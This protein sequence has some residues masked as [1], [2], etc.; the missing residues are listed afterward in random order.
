M[1]RLGQI[2]VVALGQVFASRAKAAGRGKRPLSPLPDISRL[3]RSGE[4]SHRPTD[5]FRHGSMLQGRQPLISVRTF[6]MELSYI[7]EAIGTAWKV[8]PFT[9][10]GSTLSPEYS[11]NPWRNLSLA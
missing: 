2:I 10:K 4:R 5:Q 7:T 11:S 6:G 3:G 9:R 8:A 1:I